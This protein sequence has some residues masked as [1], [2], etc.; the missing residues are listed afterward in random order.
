MATILVW[1]AAFWIVV[2]AP[3]WTQRDVE[4]NALQPAKKNRPPVANPD[5]VTVAP[6][7]MTSA[8]VISNDTD[9]EGNYPLQLMGHGSSWSWVESSSRIG[10]QAPALPGSY[11]VTYTVVD[12]LGASAQGVLNVVVSGTSE[13]S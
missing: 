2:P 6:C 4:A 8:D 9:P 3:T 12:A 1:A 10:M 11:A 13:C 7:G 5:A